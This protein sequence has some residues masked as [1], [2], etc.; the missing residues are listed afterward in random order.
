MPPLRLDSIPGVSVLRSPL[1]P[2]SS[3]TSISNI[4]VFIIPIFL[5]SMQVSNVLEALSID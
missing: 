2:L 1:S 3:N 4:V 5:L